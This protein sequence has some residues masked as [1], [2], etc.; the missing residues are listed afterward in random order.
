MAHPLIGLS[1]YCNETLTDDFEVNVSAYI[2]HINGTILGPVTETVTEGIATTVAAATNRMATTAAQNV[3]PDW[4][5]VFPTASVGAAANPGAIDGLTTSM[6]TTMFNN[7][8]YGNGSDASVCGGRKVNPTNEPN[9]AL[10]STTL[11]LGTFLLANA[12]KIFKTSHY[13]GKTVS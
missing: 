12:F 4:P 11:M 5:R 8:S 7:E 1:D 2:A 3:W 13:F 9:T 10:L 6:M